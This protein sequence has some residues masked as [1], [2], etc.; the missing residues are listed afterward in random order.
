MTLYALALVAAAL[1]RSLGLTELARR[2]I[3][4]HDELS[5]QHSERHGGGFG[6]IEMDGFHQLADHVLRRPV[7]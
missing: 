4:G 7:F 5:D 1:R 3:G 6:S 2:N